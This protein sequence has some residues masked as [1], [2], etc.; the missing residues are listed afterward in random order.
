VDWAK[1][2]KNVSFLL[3]DQKVE[4][5]YTNGEFLGQC[6]VPLLCGLEDGVVFTADLSMTIFHGELLLRRVNEIIDRMVEA[7]I[8]NYWISLHM[9]MRKIKFRKIALV[10][11]LDGYY[12]FN[13]YRM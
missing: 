11:Q 9:N 7:V 12:N 1:D 13:L 10:H 3:E 8:Y 6:S 4:Y 5:R 2:G